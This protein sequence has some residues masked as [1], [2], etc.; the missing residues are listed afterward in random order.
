MRP[1]ITHRFSGH[2][3]KKVF[4][5]LCE[6]PEQ[7][8]GVTMN[9]GQPGSQET[10]QPHPVAPDCNILRFGH[11]VAHDCNTMRSGSGSGSVICWHHAT[12]PMYEEHDDER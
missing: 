7:A 8:M 4:D 6:H 2:D 11:P 1:L 12:R 5:L 10:V 9:W 3:A